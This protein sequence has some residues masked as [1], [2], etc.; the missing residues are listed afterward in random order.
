MCRE[1]YIVS[2]LF[3][4]AKSHP[5][6]NYIPSLAFIN[7]MLKQE[8]IEL[9]AGD[10]PLEEVE[11]HLSDEL[12]YTIKHCFRCKSCKLYFLIGACIR[13]VPIYEIKENIETVNFDNI[14]WGRFGTLYKQNSR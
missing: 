14:L 13:G 5:H 1:C 12:H 3:N 7:E 11:K 4:A 2:E 6:Q 8:R 10:C 9:F